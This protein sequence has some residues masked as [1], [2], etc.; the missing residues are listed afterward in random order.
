ML[1]EESLAIRRRMESTSACRLDVSPVAVAQDSMTTE[2]MQLLSGKEYLS[3]AS[4]ARRR[5][6]THL[7]TSRIMQSADG[8]GMWQSAFSI[9]DARSHD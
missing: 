2:L 3:L 4:D 9:R 6:A 7:A 5:W 1:L 8:S